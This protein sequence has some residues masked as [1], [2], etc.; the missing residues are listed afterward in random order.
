M[1]P[2]KPDDDWFDGDGLNKDWSDVDELDSDW[3]C[4]VKLDDMECDLFELFE[5]V[6]AAIKVLGD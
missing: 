5:V 1:F 4:D 3:L 2:G 6:L